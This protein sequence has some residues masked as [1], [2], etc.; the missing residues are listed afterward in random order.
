MKGQTVAGKV[1]RTSWALEPRTR[2]LRVEIDIDN[3][4]G[5]LRPGLYAYVTVVAEEHTDVRT[6]PATAVV[7]EQDK[8]FCV[9]V[10]GGKA[11]RKPIQTGLSDGTWTE[12]VSGLDGSEKVVK[13]YATSLTDGQPVDVIEAV[14]APA[15]G[16]KP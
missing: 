1:T 3:P 16:A 2:T 9:A 7:R 5:T 10:V 6:V 13:A 4:G 14:P 8:S 15:A 11:V 12:V